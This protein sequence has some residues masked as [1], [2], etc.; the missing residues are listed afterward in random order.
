MADASDEGTRDARLSSALSSDG[1]AC[2]EIACS[3]L[4]NELLFRY[5]AI[6][7]D[8][9]R[10]FLAGNAHLGREV[11][12]SVHRELR[13]LL[14]PVLARVL[15][16]HRIALATFVSKGAVVGGAVDIHQ[17]WTFT[18]E[19][20]HR[21]LSVWLPLVDTDHR[22]GGLVV[23][24]GSHRMSDGVRPSADLDPP[25]G[26][27]QRQLWALAVQTEVPAGSALIYDTALLHGSGPNRS[28]R[29]RPCVGLVCVPEGSSLLHF[30]LR[31]DGDLRVAEIESEWLTAAPF[32]VEPPRST[33]A[34]QHRLVHS[35]EVAAWV[36]QGKVPTPR[37]TEMSAILPS[38]S[39]SDRSAPNRDAGHGPVQLL[40][41]G[42]APVSGGMF[43]EVIALIR[44]I[45]LDAS[46]RVN[47]VW[48]LGSHGRPRWTSAVESM[49]VLDDLRAWRPA[50]LASRVGGPIVGGKLRGLAWRKALAGLGA[51]DVV[52]AIDGRGLDL[53]KRARSPRTVVALWTGHTA[54]G[55]LDTILDRADLV[56]TV[57]EAPPC[58]IKGPLLE[59][60]LG[61]DG[62]A[63]RAAASSAMLARRSSP[64]GD[65]GLVV[66]LMAGAGSGAP[67]TEFGAA[68]GFSFEQIT[69]ESTAEEIAQLDALI[70]SADVS[71]RSRVVR[72]AR[73]AGLFVV[74]SDETGGHPGDFAERLS[75]ESNPHR[76]VQR[77]VA[78]TADDSTS[79]ADHW[80][81]EIRS[82]LIERND[83]CEVLT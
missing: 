34:R 73:A 51:I 70:V 52:I 16:G 41:V 80:L 53:L 74:R 9:Y 39:A 38:K 71:P 68:P 57:P 66:G 76:R 4:K 48:R 2:A 8:P 69:S 65:R 49:L 77:I 62:S 72:D 50:V 59:L 26:S 33:F 12:R 60:D 31:S 18:D 23:L 37:R 15:P 42:E 82:R 24:P 6:G 64:A 20:V 36:N 83:S 3:E 61:H 21:S 22:N 55:S 56:V 58:P 7:V 10:P 30:H 5:R 40:L 25:T 1:Y 11:A 17:D 19:R 29:E 54:V 67:L 13:A 43:D 81:F 75:D 44:A 79:V 78:E 45:H 47:A 46:T 28:N 27:F 32:G 63:A 14:D 35:E